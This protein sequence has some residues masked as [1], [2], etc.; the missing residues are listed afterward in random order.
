MSSPYFFDTIMLIMFCLYIGDVTC[1]ICLNTLR[2]TCPLA[3]LCCMFNWLMSF[4][5]TVANLMC[6]FSLCTVLSKGNVTVSVGILSRTRVCTN[7]FER[8]HYVSRKS[9]P[10]SWIVNVSKYVCFVCVCVS[11]L[12]LL[13]QKH[14]SI[15]NGHCSKLS[16]TYCHPNGSTRIK[17]YS[18]WLK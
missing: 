17:R 13:F 1:H 4:L 6:G 9:Q 7:H 8:V 10:N 12:T 11:N 2:F 15:I 18:Y 14:C 3:S 5:A 16:L